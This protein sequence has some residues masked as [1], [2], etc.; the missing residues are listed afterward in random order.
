MGNM[1]AYLDYSNNKRVRLSDIKLLDDE[2][3]SELK[4]LVDR[5]IAYIASKVDEAKGIAAS[6]GGFTD[7]SWMQRAILAR[8]LKGQL[9]QAIQ[10]EFGRRRDLRKE[11]NRRDFAD[12][13]PTRLLLAMDMVLSPDQK[14]MVLDQAEM[15]KK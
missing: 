12:S 3:L 8:K 13:L 6:G 4:Q 9:S 7:P 1:Q 15:L 2:Y 5:D 14:K 11:Q 10:K